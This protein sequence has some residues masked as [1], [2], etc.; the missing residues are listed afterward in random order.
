MV[1]KQG[2]AMLNL[3]LTPNSR[4]FS[5]EFAEENKTI[6]LKLKEKAIEGKANRAAEKA[7]KKILGCPVSIVSGHKSRDKKILLTGLTKTEAI[8]RLKKAAK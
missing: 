1:D 8:N 5:I 6:K 7:L 3:R 2:G 4:E